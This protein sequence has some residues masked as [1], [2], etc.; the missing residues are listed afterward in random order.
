MFYN[1]TCFLIECVTS[2][3]C[4]PVKRNS[5]LQLEMVLVRTVAAEHLTWEDT[6]KQESEV[7]ELQPRTETNSNMNFMNNFN[8]DLNEKLYKTLQQISAAEVTGKYPKIYGQ[9]RFVNEDDIDP[10]ESDPNGNYLN[11]KPCVPG[12]HSCG[13]HEECQLVSR[14]GG[15]CRCRPGYYRYKYKCIARSVAA[16]FQP[17]PI[18][19]ASFQEPI[20]KYSEASEEAQSSEPEK[21]KLQVSV[22]SKNIQLPE[23]EASLTAVVEPD[24]EKHTYLWSLVDKPENDKNGTITDQ[25]RQTVR[26]SNLSEGLYRF[27]LTVTGTNSY[28]EAFAN[29]TV[30]HAKRINKPPSPII[31]P[32][33]QVIKLPNQKAILDGSTS[34]DDDK[35]ESW[36]WEL[37]QAP[38]NYSP[39]LQE[40]STIELDDLKEP[41]NYTFKLTLTDSDKA[42]NSTTAMI[43]VVEEI[44]YPPQ[45]NAGADV[46]LYLPHNN[47]TLNGTLSTDDHQ[48]ISWEWTKDASDE[49]KAVD[50]QNTR[51]PYLELSHLEEGIYT[52]ELRVTDAKGQNSSSKV[53]VFVKPPTNLPPVARA[54]KA[55]TINLPL[56][57]AALNANESTDDIKITQYLW[58]QIS[59]PSTSL[60]LNADSLV[61]NATMLT[62][63]EYVFEV[64]VIDE[65]NNNATDRVKITV[66]QGEFREFI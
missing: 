33:Y 28:G 39:T 53:H 42:E 9:E 18:V 52:F 21:I 30:S 15:L 25:T 27:K 23:N 14:E 47:I 58:K 3:G 1:Q 57:W 24:D 4:L 31:T 50:M 2:A 40:Q 59:G 46:I 49:A 54:G 20:T 61:A 51:T 37:V 34:T 43:Q 29:V 10:L 22:E 63:G 32:K 35:I 66:I 19:P 60:I 13:E 38:I 12:V 6:L 45:A 5:T 36:K 8:F 62:L 56:N 7:K 44:D 41:G 16:S 48:I 64:M 26:V 65:S 55:L 17:V 11:L